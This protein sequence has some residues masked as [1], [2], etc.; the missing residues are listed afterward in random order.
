MIT[1]GLRTVVKTNKGTI[2]NVETRLEKEL[3]RLTRAYRSTAA[4][5]K[6]ADHLGQSILM[7][8]LMRKLEQITSKLRRRMEAQG[9]HT[10]E[11]VRTL[12]DMES[13]TFRDAPGEQEVA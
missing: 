1:Y 10:G 7:I 12:N 5:L 3:A 2:S 11:V 8:R 9:M 13:A 6:K 4:D